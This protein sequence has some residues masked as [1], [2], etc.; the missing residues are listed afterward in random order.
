[1]SFVSHLIA[2]KYAQCVCILHDGIYKSLKTTALFISSA[3]ASA[4]Y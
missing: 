1:M 4:S 2:M 3:I